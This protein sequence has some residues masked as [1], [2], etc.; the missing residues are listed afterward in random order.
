M[1]CLP[2]LEFRLHT[3]I[4]H[5]ITRRTVHGYRDNDLDSGMAIV[6]EP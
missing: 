1:L 6:R 3:L 4:G 5:L 2:V